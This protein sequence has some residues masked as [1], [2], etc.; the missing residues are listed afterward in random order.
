MKEDR[1]LTNTTYTSFAIPVHSH[2]TQVTSP[3]GEK[4]ISRRMMDILEHLGMKETFCPLNKYKVDQVY[5]RVT[6][7]GEYF[8]F[9]MYK[10]MGTNDRERRAVGSVL[11]AT[12]LIDWFP[13]HR[14]VDDIPLYPAIVTAADMSAR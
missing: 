5:F 9:K 8:H 11:K 10:F 2:V 1:E 3:M 6:G 7:F 12:S 13:T 4:F 14:A